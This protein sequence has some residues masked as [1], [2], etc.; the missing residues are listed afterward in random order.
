MNIQRLL[1]SLLVIFLLSNCGNVSEKKSQTRNESNNL[2]DNHSN[3]KLQ[4]NG[5]SLTFIQSIFDSLEIERGKVYVEYIGNDSIFLS[6]YIFYNEDLKYFVGDSLITNYIHTEK[7][8][9]NYGMRFEIRN[10]NHLQFFMV[11]K[12]GNGASDPII[13]EYIKSEKQFWDPFY[14]K[15]LGE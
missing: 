9:Q 12:D 13:V 8:A 2:I 11:G 4:Y 14:F 1:V 5:K 3:H 15:G 7:T 6:L 10:K